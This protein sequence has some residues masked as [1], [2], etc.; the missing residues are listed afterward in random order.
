VS[1][2]SRLRLFFALIVIVPMIALAIVV[3]LLTERSETGK[4]DAG[5]AT[6]VSAA[7][8]AHAE[9]ADATDPAVRDVASDPELQAALGSDARVERRL[10]EL[11]RAS[12]AVVSIEWRS[13]RGDL[14]ARAGSRRG[15]ALKDVS[16]SRDGR[17]VGVLAVSTT[18]AAELLARVSRLTGHELV[19]FRGGDLLAATVDG[20]ARGPS[21]AIP[22]SRAITASARLSSAAGSSVLKSPWGRRWRCWSPRTPPSSTTGSPATA[23]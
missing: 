22:G 9:A 4:V 13:T 14:M 17:R 1:F 11:V 15:L 20:W 12:P 19:V 21:S 10:D 23:C 6:G 2:R 7:S 8:G 5:V 18:E 3:F 16:L